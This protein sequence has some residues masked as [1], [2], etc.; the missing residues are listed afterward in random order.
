MAN[1]VVLIGWN[2]AVV[3]RELEAAELFGHSIGFYEAQKRA[4]NL[5]S[6]EAFFLDPHGGDMNGFILLRGDRGKLD[7]LLASDEFNAIT[8]KAIVHLEG[9]GVIRGITGELVQQRMGQYLA[10]VPKK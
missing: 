1:D 2:R 5:A 10:A 4:G 8:T 9:V 7:G 3:G 6:Y